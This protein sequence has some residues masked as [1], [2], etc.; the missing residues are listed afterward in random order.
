[1]GPGPWRVGI[2]SP[3]KAM[4]GPITLTVVNGT[5][6]SDTGNRHWA[7]PDLHNNPLVPIS[8]E[9]GEVAANSWRERAPRLN[10]D[11]PERLRLESGTRCRTSGL[12]HPDWMKT[13]Q[14]RGCAPDYPRVYQSIPT[15]QSLGWAS[16]LNLITFSRIQGGG[17]G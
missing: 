8:S 13:T 5:T 17:G 11:N 10:R 7:R 12:I 16:S 1:M 2:K 15:L 6:V 3:S 4:T 14:P 9:G